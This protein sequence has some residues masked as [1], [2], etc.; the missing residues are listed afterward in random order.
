MQKRML[1]AMLGHSW[2]NVHLGFT[3]YRDA[4]FLNRGSMKR[5]VVF[6]GDATALEAIECRTAEV[7]MYSISP[8]YFSAA[9]ASL[10]CPEGA[11]TW[12]DD[13]NAPRVAVVNQ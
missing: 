9:A 5:S 8:G 3:V 1:E 11:F 12:H 2:C 7:P 4:L 6:A 10:S 13:Q